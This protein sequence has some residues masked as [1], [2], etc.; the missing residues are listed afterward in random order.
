[1]F[2]LAK[3]LDPQK[4]EVTLC[5]SNYPSLTKWQNDFRDAGFTTIEINVT[6]KH[7]PRHYFV[8]KKILQEGKFD[9]LHC[10]IWNPASCRYALQAA[11]STKTPIISTEHDPF[12]LSGIKAE[13]KKYQLRH[14]KKI[15]CI[16]QSNLDL[17]KSIY[18]EN[19]DKLTLIH[20][21]IDIED[22]E[23]KLQA[24]TNTDKQNFLTES[25]K[26]SSSN[27]KIIACIAALHQRKGLDILI[28]AFADFAKQN[29]NYQLLISGSGPEADSLQNLIH[30]LK[31]EN[32]VFLLGQTQNIPLLLASANYFVLPSR[33]EAFGLVL[34]E[35]MCAK[36][37]ILS[38]KTGGISEILSD[39]EAI[40]VEPDNVEA[41]QAGLNTLTKQDE[42]EI[43]KKIQ[44]AYDKLRKEFSAKKMA[45]SSE[46]VYDAVIL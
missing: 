5:S 19:T 1:M 31:L 40:L 8:V 7:D 26:N 24:V 35:A 9:I 44:F 20:N 13:I 46:K 37:P 6:H 32:K 21:G 29:Q 39:Q 16:S 14:I 11:I 45:E 15:I 33:R 22:F 38:T 28:N 3:F 17:L 2:L 25:T 34:L 42:T 18:P 36:L 43:A 10:H 12:P 27:N 23:Q 30:N 4:Y 41:L